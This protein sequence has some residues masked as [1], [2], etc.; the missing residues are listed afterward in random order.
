MSDLDEFDIDDLFVGLGPDDLDFSVEDA[1]MEFVGSVLA[2]QRL[3]LRV[4]LADRGL[5]VVQDDE[6]I[7]G[8]EIV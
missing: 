8:E 4:Q 3:R 1:R 2:S 6:A 5:Y 7:L